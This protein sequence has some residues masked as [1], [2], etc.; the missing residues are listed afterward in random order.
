MNF[1]RNWAVTFYHMRKDSSVSLTTGYG[2]DDRGLIPE[3]CR[4]FSAHCA[5]R[6]ALGPTQPL[7]QW[8]LGL[9]LWRIESQAGSW[10]LT[11]I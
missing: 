9:L 6:Q 10:P 4:K 7:T 8:V 2:L 1:Y 5:S 3:S 11:S